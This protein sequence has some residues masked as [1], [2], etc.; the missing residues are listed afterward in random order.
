MVLLEWM[1]SLVII[2]IFIQFFLIIVDTFIILDVDLLK[3]HSSINIKLIKTI[4]FWFIIV[5]Y[6]LVFVYTIPVPRKM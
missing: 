5:L 3:H 4:R 1:C 2:F 6:F